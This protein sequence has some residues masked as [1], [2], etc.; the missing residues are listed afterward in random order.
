MAAKDPNL[1][2]T[3]KYPKHS[4]FHLQ[5]PMIKEEL[6]ENDRPENSGQSENEGKDKQRNPVRRNN[7]SK[8]CQSC[9]QKQHLIYKCPDYLKLDVKERFKLIRTKNCC[10]NC[11][12][13]THQQ[14]NCSSKFTCLID[15]CKQ[16]HHTSL[17]GFF[18]R[19]PTTKP[20]DSDST[21]NESP[22]QLQED[23]NPSSRVHTTRSINKGRVFLQVVPIKI[24]NSSGN[25]IKTYALLDAGS[26]CTIL[27]KDLCQLLKLQGVNKQI[28][29]GTLKGSGLPIQSKIVDIEISS[30]DDTFTTKIR[31][32]FSIGKEHFHV[33]S[34]KLPDNPILSR[35]MC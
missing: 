4:S 28:D 11:L 6:K 5:E 26:Q 14:R 13:S 32:V 16:K 24:T 23:D 22:D 29:L 33:P 15:G 30:I 7:Q 9:G 19:K 34:Q 8:S 31:N 2:S 25:K 17:H 10:F 3:E 18:S 35:K 27:R 12:S 1:P 21:S 20:K